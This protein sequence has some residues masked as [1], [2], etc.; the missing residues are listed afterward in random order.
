MTDAKTQT[1]TIVV[2]PGRLSFPNLLEPKVNDDGAS[3]FETTL[4]LPPDTDVSK[5]KKALEAVA[6]ETFGPKD[7]WPRGMRTPDDVI[8]DCS[9]KNFAGYEEGWS[10]IAAALP[11]TDRNG[12]AR[13]GPQILDAMKQ[14]VT[15]ASEVYA[16]RWAK[17]ALRPYAYNN[18]SKGVTLALVAVQLLK[19][20]DRLGGGVNAKSLFD[21]E[22]EDLDV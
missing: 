21:E 10:F 11:G 7:K 18:K 20:D 14:E 15:N 6:I 1:P 12:K 8:R 13:P 17:L 2:G 19:H 9:E 16:G 22:A 3:R 4:L 5:L